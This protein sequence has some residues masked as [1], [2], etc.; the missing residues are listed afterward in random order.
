MK[1]TP[2]QTKHT[3]EFDLEVISKDAK[4]DVIM[5]CF[6]YV[7][8]GRDNVEV[9]CSLDCKR[10]VTS[11]MKYFLKSFTP[12]NY[13]CHL[14]QHTELW[15]TYHALFNQDKKEYFKSKVKHIN[16]LHQHMDQTMESIKFVISTDIVDTIIVD[17]FFCNDEQLFND[18]NNDDDTAATKVIAKRATKKSKEKVN[19][20]RL[21]IK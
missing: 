10:K 9:G 13:C 18:S 6:F 1:S 2:F 3:L 15:A 17:I 8:K 16:T 11:T 19:T 12:F 21:F 14:K 5:Q 20:M 7:H 4:R